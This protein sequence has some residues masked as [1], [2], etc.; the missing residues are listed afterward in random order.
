MKGNTLKEKLTPVWWIAQRE[1]IDQFRD[2]RILFPLAVLTFLFPPLMNLVAG[3]AVEFAAKYGGEL[4]LDRLVPF[5]ILI[6]GFFPVTAALVVALE[7]FVGEKERGTIEA[8]LG[9]PFLDWQLYLGKFFVGVVFP[10]LASYTSIAIYI[11]MVKK[12]DLSLPSPN[13]MAQLLIL[14]A[15][16]ALLMVA[17]AI[18]I[19]TQST[20]VRAA[21]LLASFIIL[22]VA[23]L[24]QAESF[25]V[26]WGNDY[27][28][29]L[30]AFAVLIIAILLI[31]V[32]LAHFQREYLLGREI[33]SINLKWL[34]RTFRDS[35]IG[36]AKTPFEWYK[37]QV[38]A[39]L[40][41]I[42]TPLLLLSISAVFISIASYQVTS[43][44][45]PAE[46]VEK[47]ELS[48]GEKEQFL[49]K[50]QSAIGLPSDETEISF[51]FIFFHNI[52]AVLVM[53]LLGLLSLGILGEL[54]FVVNIGIIGS[55]FAVLD[56]VGMSAST[57]FIAGVLPHGIFEI[58]AIIFASAAILYFGAIMV[59][60]NPERTMGVVFVHAISDW[61]KISVGIIL[62]LLLVAA[63]IE[64]YITPQ[65]LAY[66]VQ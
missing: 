7:A 13:L 46:I 3:S 47:I 49:D 55:V 10:L 62:P 8:L 58:P 45:L 29:W 54:A 4:I 52:R 37:V 14:A 59:T 48:D 40:Q 11:F 39:S 12:Q 23:F 2:W 20:S 33:D 24:L 34:G 41:K 16:H 53:F 17:G 66:F 9:A 38:G 31:R 22:P 21:N 42:K 57:L 43:A 35:F 15:V 25:F 27:L 61:L 36:E 32:G 1:L 30:V 28:L 50:L 6:I 64:T 56:G 60:P 44:L 63:L 65:I 51:G 26:F 19:S 18:A 5:S